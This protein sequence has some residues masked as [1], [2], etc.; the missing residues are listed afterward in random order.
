M[1]EKILELFK[2]ICNN[3]YCKNAV[4]SLTLNFKRLIEESYY[5]KIYPIL[6]KEWI[7]KAEELIK[8]TDIKNFNLTISFKKDTTD[9]QSIWYTCNIIFHGEDKIEISFD[10]LS[11]YSTLNSYSFNNVVKDKDITNYR[12]NIKLLIE[13]KNILVQHITMVDSQ[14]IKINDIK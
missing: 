3:E 10:M 14:L 9:Y 12:E 7:E 13:L 1:K 2:E 8:K 4:F 5:S 11:N 6:N